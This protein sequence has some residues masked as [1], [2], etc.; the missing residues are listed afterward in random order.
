LPEDVKFVIQLGGDYSRD[1]CYERVSIEELAKPTRLTREYKEALQRIR[2]KTIID[3]LHNNKY[4]GIVITDYPHNRSVFGNWIRVLPNYINTVNVRGVPKKDKKSVIWVGRNSEEKR[5]ELLFE[6]ARKLPDY[7]FTLVLSGDFFHQPK[8]DDVPYNINLYPNLTSRELLGSLYLASDIFLLTSTT[9][10]MPLTILEALSYGCKIVSS[11][12]GNINNKTVPNASLI[13]DINDVN[14]Y[15][16]QIKKWNRARK[17]D[18]IRK[19]NIQFGKKHHIRRALKSITDIY[20]NLMK[21]SLLK[22]EKKKSGKLRLGVIVDVYGWAWD[23]ATRELFAHSKKLSGDIYSV[24]DYRNKKPDMNKYD[25]ILVYPWTSKDIVKDLDPAK[26]IICIAGADQLNLLEDFKK[27]CGEFNMIGA[28]NTIIH[29]FFSMKLPG[30]QILLLSHG[31][32]ARLFKPNPIQHKKFTVGWVGRT[33]RKLKRFPKAKNIV[34][35]L[36]VEFKVADYYGDGTYEYYK[37]EDM[38]KFFNSIDCLLVTSTM[39]AHPMVIYEA[40]SCGIPVITTD[41]GDVSENIIHTVNGFILP[42]KESNETFISYIKLL[43][44]SKEYRNTIGSNARQ[45]ILQKW[46]WGKIA[47]QYENLE[48]LI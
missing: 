15:K 3:F 47:P 37:H 27:K 40:M 4:R 10:G 34:K 26:T 9:E 21:V 35:K 6:L 42:I 22:K 46:R 18:E 23:I 7:S 25:L 45:T 20:T 48:D 14:E 31:I 41:V 38:P 16:K 44:D 19:K 36:N 11:E 12:V 32:D 8:F 5:P 1:V 2:K 39:E 24:E 30:K 28:C 33:K 29:Q 43:M 13:K 17:K